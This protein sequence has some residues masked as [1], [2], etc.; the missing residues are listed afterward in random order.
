L[1][2]VTSGDR[3]YNLSTDTVDNRVEEQEI[4]DDT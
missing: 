4:A 1:F 2:A 3:C